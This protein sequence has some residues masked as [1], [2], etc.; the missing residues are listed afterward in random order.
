[1]NGGVVIMNDFAFGLY[2]SQIQT[3]SLLRDR[4]N[5]MSTVDL[6]KIYI[7]LNSGL[8]VEETVEIFSRQALIDEILLSMGN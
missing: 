1:M 3:R 6:R 4:L 2:A 7:R 5:K 8:W